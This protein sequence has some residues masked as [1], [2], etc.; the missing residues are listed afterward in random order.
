MLYG[1]YMDVVQDDVELN[2]IPQV[3]LFD[4]LTKFNGRKEKVGLGCVLTRE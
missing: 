2:S 4:L 3:P 1:C